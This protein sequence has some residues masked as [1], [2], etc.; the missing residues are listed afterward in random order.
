MLTGLVRRHG[1]LAREVLAGAP[2]DAG[3]GRRFGDDLYAFEV[4]YLV[5]REWARCVDDVVWRRTKAGLRLDAAARAS[6]ADYL[7]QITG[8]HRATSG[9]R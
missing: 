2:E 4:D 5:R 9:G 8:K 3:N 1:S 7:R 6:L